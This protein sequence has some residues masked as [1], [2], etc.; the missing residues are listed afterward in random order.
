MQLLFTA[1]AL[2]LERA[3]TDPVSVL[4]EADNFPFVFVVG[5]RHSDADEVGNSSRNKGG[6]E[7]YRE[8]EATRRAR[9]SSREHSL[10]KRVKAAAKSVVVPQ[11]TRP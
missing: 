7:K 6:G 10:V 4:E 5:E 9:M 3:Q 1:T 11:R 8:T 2:Y